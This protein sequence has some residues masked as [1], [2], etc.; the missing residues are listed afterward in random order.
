MK[1][2]PMTAS[3]LTKLESRC[4]FPETFSGSERNKNGIGFYPH[5]KI[6]HIRADY[7]GWRWWNTIWPC[8]DELATPE[9]KRE[10]DAVYKAAHRK[11]RLLRSR[12]IDAILRIS[13]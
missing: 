6:G 2:N 10:I 4:S 9:M 11:R 5:S 13:P 1:S 7:D 3:I 12:R 8:H